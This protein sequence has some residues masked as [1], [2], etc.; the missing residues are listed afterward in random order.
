MQHYLHC[1]KPLITAI[2]FVFANT[3]KPIE[4]LETGLLWQISGKNC[5][6]M[7]KKVLQLSKAVTFNHNASTYCYF[8]PSLL[9]YDIHTNGFCYDSFGAKYL[10]VTYYLLNLLIMKTFRVNFLDG[11]SPTLENFES[12]KLFIFFNIFFRYYNMHIKL[13]IF[14]CTF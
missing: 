6:F 7:P 14:F 10:S 12:P 2:G 5:A 3:N 11:V 4:L 1:E 13:C 8:V 9:L